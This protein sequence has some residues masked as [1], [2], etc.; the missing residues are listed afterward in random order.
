[1]IIVSKITEGK[2]ENDFKNIDQ[3]QLIKILKFKGLRTELQIFWIFL[4][5]CLHDLIS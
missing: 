5:R 2:E 4:K 1:M 3:N